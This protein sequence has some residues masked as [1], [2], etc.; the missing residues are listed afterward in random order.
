M[1][2][3]LNVL[4][5]TAEFSNETLDLIPKVADLGFDGIE[6][7]FINLDAIDPAATRRALEGAGVGATG[8]AVLV[9]GTNL[10]S[11]EAAERAPSVIFFDEVEALVPSRDH[12][13][14]AA[15]TRVVT[16]FLQ[17]LGG[18]NTDANAPF[19]LSIGA[20]NKPWR[21]DQAF[22]SRF[23]RMV[24]V[25]LPDRTCR[26]RIFELNL[27]GRGIRSELDAEDLADLAEGYSGREI[28]QVC[29]QAIAAAIRSSN[30]ELE[31]L[32]GKGREAVAEYELQL[33]PIGPQHFREALSQVKPVSDGTALQRYADWAR[34]QGG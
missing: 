19:V 26:T 6:I 23:A 2:F 1:K 30:P 11:D 14:S 4:L 22:L 16:A 3:G 32:I 13:I 18:F 34:Q 8:C 24:Y 25:P 10:I 31:S 5:Y 20:T 28:A 7:P 12:D 9:P 15:E 33:D 27:E 17:A 21:L 29:E